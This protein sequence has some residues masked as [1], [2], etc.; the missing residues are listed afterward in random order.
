M[1]EGAAAYATLKATFEKISQE[2]AK[3]A[4]ESRLKKMQ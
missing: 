4:E 2:K 1:T 3:A